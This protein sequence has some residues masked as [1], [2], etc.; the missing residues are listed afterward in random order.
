M[1]TKVGRRRATAAAAVLGIAPLVSGCDLQVLDPA[2]PI[3]AGER[4]I[5]FNSLV[6]MLCIIVPTMVATVVFVW[7]FRPDNPKAKRLPT[8]S[9]SGRLEI[10]TW[11][12][13]LMAIMFLG[14]VTWI[15]SHELDPAKPIIGNKK[16]LEVQVVSLDW[17]WLFIY[18]SQRVA[19]VN[20]LVIPADRPIHFKLT[21]ASVWNAFFVPRLGSMIYTMNGMTT[22]LWLQADQP[23]SFHSLSAHLSGEGFA[24]MNF[25][26]KAVS[27]SEFAEWVAGIQASQQAL[28]VATY[29]AMTKQSVNDPPATFR[30]AD[31]ALFSKIVTQALPP[32]PGPVSG[33]P[34]PDV[35]PK[36]GS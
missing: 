14:G 23:G 5:L 25:E 10:V 26:T 27:D 4:L 29:T 16:P 31:S 36:Q 18:P 35:A 21:S 8:W 20:K 19:S 9:F 33:R 22:Q 12:I 1:L 13:P 32:G 30:L 17:K 24:D 7:W 3:A 28:D 15:G 34:S 11:A 6:I 2:G